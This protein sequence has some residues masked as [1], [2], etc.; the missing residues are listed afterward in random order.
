MKIKYNDIEIKIQNRIVFTKGNPKSLACE[1]VCNYYHILV[2]I[3]RNDK[4]LYDMKMDFIKKDDSI[5]SKYPCSEVTNYL[6]HKVSELYIGKEVSVND[7]SV[8]VE[9]S[10]WEEFF[11]DSKVAKEARLDNEVFVVEKRF[12]YRY[13]QEDGGFIQVIGL[14]KDYVFGLDIYEI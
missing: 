6:Q 12:P 7:I 10:D 2:D 1:D 14:R 13:F 9:R 5:H 11:L 4:S 3:I 8:I